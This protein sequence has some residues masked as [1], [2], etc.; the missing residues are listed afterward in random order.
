MLKEFAI[1]ENL[2]SNHELKSYETKQ[3]SSLSEAEEIES[4]LRPKKRGSD[5]N[6]SGGVENS[7]ESVG[8]SNA[9][10]WFPFKQN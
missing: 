2:I 1:S 4:K 8:R 6:S 10:S 5:N 7:E 3:I 9:R